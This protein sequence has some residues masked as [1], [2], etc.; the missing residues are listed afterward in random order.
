MHI[1]E[2]TSVFHAPSRA[3]WR[4]WLEANHQSAAEIWLQSYHKKSGVSSVPYDDAVEEALCF[5]WIDGI[6]KSY[7]ERSAVQRYTP[8]R[9][10]SFLSE[11]NRQRAFKMIRK[12]LMTEAGLAP[13]Q[14]ML[15]REDDPLQLPEAIQQALQSDPQ[16]WEHFQQ[17][18]LPYQKLRIGFILENARMTEQRLAYFLKMT[19]QGKRYGTIVGD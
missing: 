18:P 2:I 15:G 5:G 11:L 8:R 10:K 14:H 4:A 1:M 12:G 9:K 3:E 16:V 13:I 17:F 6:A 19:R 7:D